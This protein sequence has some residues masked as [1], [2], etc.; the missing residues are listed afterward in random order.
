MPEATEPI[1]DPC[2]RGLLLLA[3]AALMPGVY[4][5]YREV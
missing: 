1:A 2:D 4:Y 5:C 3:T